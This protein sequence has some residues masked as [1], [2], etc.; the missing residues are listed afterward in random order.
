MNHAFVASPGGIDK[1]VRCKF[2][3]IAHTAEAIC[4]TCPNVG[5]VEIRH[6]NTLMCATC[7]D[8]DLNTRQ[9]A[10]NQPNS[11]YT[12]E[13]QARHQAFRE[14]RAKEHEEALNKV[15]AEAKEKDLKVQLRT[16]MYNAATESIKE[17]KVTIDSDSAIQNKPYT[18]A[19]Q[20]KTRFEHFQSVVFAESQVISDAEKK[21]EEAVNNQKAIQIY[22]NTLANQ[23]RVEEREK[24]HIA[25]IQYN[26]S[27]PKAV[28]TKNITTKKS[29]KTSPA[30]L[31]KYAQEIGAPTYILQQIIISKGV[32][33]KT[34]ADILKKSMNKAELETASQESGFPVEMIQSLMHMKSITISQAIAKLKKMALIESE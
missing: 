6:G 4:E 24:L 1:C 25:D 15:L 19:E 7:W 22:M 21:I 2:P 9:I 11:P 32:D 10:A 29:T 34:A 12:P 5:P 18:L 20:L 3:Y 14:A 8:K 16:D 26:P 28:K 23:L 30:E 17:L 27:A 31:K 33:V 13:Q